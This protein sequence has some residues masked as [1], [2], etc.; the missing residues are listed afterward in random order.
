MTTPIL[1]IITVVLNGARTLE[2][3]LES[4]SRHHSP[5]I[6]HLV[7]DGGSTD[8]TV[9][10]LKRHEAH[11]AYWHSQPDKGIYDAMNQAVAKARGQW[12]LFLGCDDEW[13]ISPGAILPRLQS[14]HTIYYGNAYWTHSQRTYD[15]PFSAAKLARTNIC[16]QAI[17]YPLAALKKHPY[18]LKYRLQADWELNMRC[19]RD[20]DLAFEYLPLTIANF[21]DG[22][23]SSRHFRDLVMEADYPRLLCQYF[24]GP[25]AVWLSLLVLGGRLLRKLGM[26]ASAVK[27][28]SP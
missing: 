9:N 7:L 6:E 22:G 26:K 23:A 15:G 8:G 1:S 28:P 14:A 3:C 18:N 24:P 20:P 27:T 13:V 11:L 25:T 4:V 17:L 2:K 5:E 12:V 19:F 16:Q 21:N 10:I